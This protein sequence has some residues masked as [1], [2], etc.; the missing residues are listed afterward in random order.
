MD[1]GNLYLRAFKGFRECHR[2][3]QVYVVVLA[4]EEGVRVDVDLQIGVAFR[5]AV[6]AETPLALK[7]KGL[8]VL[9]ALRD[10]HV[11][12]LAVGKLDPLAHAGC[13]I[14][15]TDLHAVV[16]VGAALLGSAAATGLAVA[17]T[18]G[19]AKQIGENLVGCEVLIECEAAVL[20]AAGSP[21]FRIVAI[22]A[23]LRRFLAAGV[24]L[25]GI[26]A[27]AF[28]G[29]A[30]DSVGLRNLL[31]ALFDLGVARIE[32]WMQF[33]SQLAISCLDLVLAGAAS[34]AQRFVRI[35][36][37]RPRVPSDQALH[38]SI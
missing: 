33:L 25:S 37:R 22:E 34:N 1:G 29:I 11:E 21:G 26:E 12:C 4:D 36:H 31:E 27:F 14:Q 5:A 8:T 15:E 6:E 19:A 23:A 7:S 28:V 24:D 9:H 38:G 16:H 30:Q 10:R 20:V 17:A 2:H 32:I 18:E 3:L 35:A 13:R